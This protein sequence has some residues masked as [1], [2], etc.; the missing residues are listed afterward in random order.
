MKGSSHRPRKELMFL[1]RWA[2]YG[3]EDDT[4]ERWDNCKNSEAVQHF[5]RTHKDKR[6][7]RLAK[8]IEMT[9]SSNKMETEENHYQSDEEIEPLAK[10]LRSNKGQ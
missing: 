3:P 1:L 9:D 4:W 2:G 10:R 5:L 7:Q 8:K 6:I